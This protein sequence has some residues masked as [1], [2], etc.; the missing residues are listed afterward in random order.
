M[1]AAAA[2][3]TAAGATVPG[4]GERTRAR[5]LE[6]AVRRFAADG[7]R[8]TS[9]S[10][11]ARDAGLTP[12]AVYAYFAG[13][14]ALFKAAVDA[15]AGALIEKASAVAAGQNVRGEFALRV[16]ELVARLGEHPLAR[17]VLA[18][19]EPEV[20]GRLLDLPSLAALTAG[21]ADQLAAGQ[22]AGE[23]RADVDPGAVA[24]GMEAI[25]LCLLMGVVQAG[26]D[27]GSEMGAAVAEVL[28]AALRPPT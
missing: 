9:V 25:V 12:A 8:R 20:V 16:A 28:D 24:M 19:Q 27:P 1:T 6:I 14:E 5:L 17:R 21:F 15:D 26:V 23:V 13:K 2:P 22:A 10:D 3:P 18:G 7:Y 11:V 4:K